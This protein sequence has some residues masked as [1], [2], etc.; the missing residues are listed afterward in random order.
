MRC[1]KQLAD[2]TG[3]ATTLKLMLGPVR[4]LAALEQPEDL[5]GARLAL[6]MIGQFNEFELVDKASAV[7]LS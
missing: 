3:A 6:H 5:T 7:T 4:T 1:W 2:L